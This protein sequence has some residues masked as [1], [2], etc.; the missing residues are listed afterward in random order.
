MNIKRLLLAIITFLSLYSVFFALGQSLGQP[1]IQARLEL[2]QTNLILHATELQT[3]PVPANNSSRNLSTI[4]KTLIGNNPYALAQNQYQ[5]ALEITQKAVRELEKQEE[6]VADAVAS[7]SPGQ[8]LQAELTENKDFVKELEIKLGI[9]AAKQNKIDEARQHWQK[10]EN[11]QTADIL[12]NL[13]NQPPQGLDNAVA[14]INSNVDGWFR[15]AVLQRIYQLENKQAELLTLANSEK[16]LARK[17]ILKLITLSTIPILGGLLGLGLIILLLAE[18]LIKKERSILATNQD[19]TWETPWDWEI[20][21]QVLIVGFFFISQVLLPLLFGM[22]GLNPTD[23]T[24]RGKAFYVLATYLLMSGGG[25]LVLYV[26][27]K[28][29]FPLPPDWFRFQGNNWPA[30]GI[31][32]YLIAIPSVFLVSIINQQLW[33]GQGG[34]NPLLFLALKAQDRVALAIFLFTASVAAPVFEEIMFRGFLLPSLTRYLPVWGAIVVSALIFAF[35][36][37]SLAEVI[38]LATLGLILGFVYTRSRNLLSSILIHSLWNSGTL[39]S[40][41]ILGSSFDA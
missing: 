4:S 18:R 29:F 20:I 2:Y 28:S 13:W 11:N 30:W 1:Q 34:S 41:F 25:L 8:K 9:L 33:H 17:A 19:L 24:I 10:L 23:F 6:I 39:F 21:W 35:A 38:P 22:I 40:L 12:S 5:Q 14:E 32:G 3:D 36:H 37:L 16:K 31:G 15:Y 7:D 27:L 26:S